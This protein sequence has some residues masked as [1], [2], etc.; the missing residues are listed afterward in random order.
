VFDR[1]GD[2]VKMLA[3]QAAEM[4]G[5][6]GI[7]QPEELEVVVPLVPVGTSRMPPVAPP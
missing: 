2:I 4:V 1:D 3:N 7:T 5:S 6:E